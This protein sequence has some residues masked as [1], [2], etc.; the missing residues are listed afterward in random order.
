MISE[1]ALLENVIAE[2]LLCFKL[3]CDSCFSVSSLLLEMSLSESPGG[4]F[5]E[6]GWLAEPHHHQVG[7]PMG[8]GNMAWAKECVKKGISAM[9]DFST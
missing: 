2:D 6:S 1:M 5:R 3:P 4:A 9:Q 7:T 8:V